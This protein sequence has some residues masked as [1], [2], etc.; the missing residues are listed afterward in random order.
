M[1]KQAPLTEL[2]DAD[3]RRIDAV[4]GPANGNRFLIAKAEAPNMV[5]D[6]AV[7][8]LIA[9]PVG[10][11]YI[12][13]IE[14]SEEAQVAPVK[15]AKEPRM[16]TKTAPA[17]KTPAVVVGDVK[18]AK[19]ILKQA[20]KDRKTAKLVKSARK[21]EK[22]A[23]LA[24]VNALNL[25]KGTLGS[26]SDAHAALLD[27]LKNEASKQDGGDPSDTMTMLQ[28][29][30]D[31][32]AG[33]MSTHAA[34]GGDDDAEPDAMPEGEP[35]GDE[36]APIEKKL[37]VKKARQIAKA[38][39]LAK[40][41]ARDQ[42]KTAKARHTLAKI[43]RRNNASDQAH[44]DAIDEH[45]AALGA[46]AHQT[47]KPVTSVAKSAEAVG[48]NLEQIQAVVGPITE[49]IRKAIQGELSQISEQVA[50]IAKTA[51]P[52]GPRVVM[53][54]DGA[55]IGA[56]DGQVGMTPE[57]ATLTKAAELF[58]AGSVQREKLEK[59]AAKI[60]IKGLMTAQQ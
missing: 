32:L 52:G 10:D 16:A 30:A 20:A 54:R 43:G 25:T 39:K 14:K 58:P 48:Y 31:K 49:D 53:D 42:I 38:A 15:K 29:F 35:D 51:L 22:K 46:S 33:L 17:E 11:V 12:G 60:A 45:A 6:E 44:V 57:Q 7:R 21:I 26:L 28:G 2:V 4:K 1:S 37:N 36:A 23:L 5:S 27:A 8:A 56:G 47:S 59:E 40:Q 50:K 13:D 9:D 55:I 18:K 34:S 3:I 24:Q 19:A 41:T